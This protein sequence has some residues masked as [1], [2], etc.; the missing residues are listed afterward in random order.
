MIIDELI[1]LLGFKVDE[2]SASKA[3]GAISGVEA[4]A[5]KLATALGAAGL[6]AGFVK[7]VEFGHAASETMERL[8]TVFGPASQGVTDWSDSF[9]KEVGRSRKDLQQMTA[10]VGAMV[11]PM[12]VSQDAAAEMGKGLAELAVN[13]AELNDADDKS[14]MDAL[15]M[16]LAGNVRAL[17]Q[18]GLVIDETDMKEAGRQ[19]GINKGIKSLTEAERAQV[20]YQAI[21]NKSAGVAKAGLDPTEAFD[22]RIQNLRDSIG[23]KLLPVAEWLAKKAIVI[24]DYFEDLAKNTNIVEVAFALLAPVAMAAG[25]SLIAPFLPAIGMFTALAIIIDDIVTM[26]Q[27]GDSVLGRFLDKVGGEG[28]ST[29]FVEKIKAGFL[30]FKRV[31]K[32]DVWPV[33]EKVFKEMK[34][35]L[36][37]LLVELP[38]FGKALGDHL[39]D[40]VQKVSGWLDSITESLETIAKYADVVHNIGK[41]AVGVVGEK[42]GLTDENDDGNELNNGKPTATTASG[43]GWLGQ[44]ARVTGDALTDFWKDEAKTSVTVFR[45]FTPAGGAQF[46]APINQTNIFQGVKPSEVDGQLKKAAAGAGEHLRREMRDA[47]AGRAK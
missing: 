39:F 22:A 33:I 41:V 29:D 19:L 31:M 36:D 15:R 12:G 30:E 23:L 7:L 27:G 34:N 25:W 47:A 32:E 2:G 26:F 21:L 20:S 24:I 14:T 40:M 46:S 38:A 1:A 16:G 5:G 9:G 10:S 4:A 3:K 11:G 8:D 18:Y 13:L 37:I 6:A 17:K 42:L 28:T 43:E 45:P 44:M 35:W